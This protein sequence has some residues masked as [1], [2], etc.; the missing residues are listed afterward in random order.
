MRRRDAYI[1]SLK[2]GAYA[3]DPPSPID[4]DKRIT[5]ALWVDP[6]AQPHA[7]AEQM[8]RVYPEAAQ[9]V[10][11]GIIAWSPRMRATLTGDAFAITPADGPNFDGIKELSARHRTA[12][13]WDIVPK[14]PGRRQLLRLKLDAVL[15][16][17]LGKPREVK[18]LDREIEVEVTLWW[19]FD[20]YWEKYWKW[21]LGG[22]AGALGSVIA[23]L[24]TNRRPR[25]GGQPLAPAPAR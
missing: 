8:K 24:F 25:S 20:H 22:L 5:V 6:Q 18:V 21:M 23:W 2:Q 1:E 19:L 14:G 15:P 9:R 17:E 4:V 13:A 12:W 7:L 16:E 11:S 10:E 3:F